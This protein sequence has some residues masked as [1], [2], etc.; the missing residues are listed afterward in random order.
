MGFKQSA[1]SAFLGQVNAPQY[2]QIDFLPKLSGGVC[3]A[4]KILHC[5]LFVLCLYLHLFRAV[6]GQSFSFL[7]GLIVLGHVRICWLLL[8]L[9]RDEPAPGALGRARDSI[10]ALPSISLLPPELISF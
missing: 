1:A 3:P 6:L 7:E 8:V 2:P 5:L 4:L 9:R 10:V